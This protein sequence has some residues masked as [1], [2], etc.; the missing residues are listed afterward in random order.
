MAAAKD[1]KAVVKI[2]VGYDSRLSAPELSA[3][4][5]GGLI[6]ASAKKVI[7]CGLASTPAMFMGTVYKRD[8]F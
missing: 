3:A 5:L 8:C 2:G 4:A 1:K 6:A 7:D